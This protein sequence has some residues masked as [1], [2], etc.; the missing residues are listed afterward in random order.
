ME[1]N[2]SA[3]TEDEKKPNHPVMI[4]QKRPGANAPAAIAVLLFSVIFVAGL[5]FVVSRKADDKIR[6]LSSSAAP[7]A[8]PSYG[9][10]NPKVVINPDSVSTV[11]PGTQNAQVLKFTVVAPPN[12]DIA[13]YTFNFNFFDFTASVRN[14]KL[15]AEGGAQYGGTAPELYQNQISF[16]GLPLTIAAGTQKTFEVHLDIG[17]QLP[18]VSGYGYPAPPYMGISLGAI[19]YNDSTASSMEGLP[20]SRS[21]LI[22]PTALAQL[23]AVLAPTT[24]PVQTVAP[25]GTKIMT[26]HLQLSAGAGADVTLDQLSIG[27]NMDAKPD[28]LSNIRVYDGDV[29]LAEIPKLTNKDSNGYWG[30]A[31]FPNKLVIA[32]GSTKVIRVTV[33]LPTKQTFKFRT[34]LVGVGYVGAVQFTGQLPLYGNTITVGESPVDVAELSVVVGSNSPASRTVFPG[35][36]GVDFSRVNLSAGANQKVVIDSLTVALNTN[37]DASVV[38]NVRVMAG[39][40]VVAIIPSLTKNKEGYLAGTANLKIPLVIPQG[41]TKQLSLYGDIVSSA[42]RGITLKLGIGALSGASKFK[43]NGVLPVYG[44][45]MTVGV[46]R[47]TR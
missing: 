30:T 40:I 37:T 7:A 21:V 33:N 43:I 39:D 35:D 45:T 9:Y 15:F 22:S 47:I 3:L 28:V 13:L 38:K 23:N 11:A 18:P 41:A 26:T 19:Y 27:A 16:R 20:I 32:K 8:R 25:G 34:G 36:S 29:F 6:P 2:S 5:V 10:L 17:T 24:P 12:R 14:I 1:K 42:K 31:F 44:N 4:A 46:T